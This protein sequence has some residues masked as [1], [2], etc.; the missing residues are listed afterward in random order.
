M[1]VATAIFFACFFAMNIGASGTAAS[2][3]PAYGGG[4][5]RKKWVAVCLVGIVALFGAI[6]GGGE[7]TKTMSE[8]VI[9][10][11]I[12]THTISVLIIASSAAVLFFSNKMGIPLST[13]EVTVG[14]IIGVGIAFGKVYILQVIGI[15]S[16][17]FVLPI[18][19]YWFAKGLD[20]LV[21]YCENR[22]LKAYT[23]RK[24]YQ[25]LLIIFLIFFGCYEG[26]A[27]GMN[28]VANAIGPLIA[29]DILSA[30]QGILLGAIF[31]CLGAMLLGGPVLETNGKKITKLS[32]VQGSVVSFT[33]GSLVIIASLFGIPVPLTQ[34]TTMSIIGIGSN[35]EEKHTIWQ[36]PVVKR[37]LLVWV[38]S[39][40]IAMAVSYSL[41]QLF[42]FGFYAPFIVCISSF[43]LLFF[44]K[45]LKHGNI[46][47]DTNKL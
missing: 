30:Q 22:W 40:L 38:L 7:V 46:I 4:A 32:L 25:R 1:L 28:N 6:F 13:S 47:N 43:I 31:M 5:I 36:H 26:F 34:A 27:A 41:V 29:S 24:W 19:A 15:V 35:N 37:I 23:K 21:H 12:V 33:S 8:G 39:P 16:V 20:R 18:T 14:S 10:Q 42:V 45:T 2:I 44:Y 9:P 17:W 3:G 11:D